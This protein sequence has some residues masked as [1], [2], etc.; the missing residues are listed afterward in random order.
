MATNKRQ[1]FSW[2]VADEIALLKEVMSIQPS[3]VSGWTWV[4]ENLN[5]MFG[6]RKKLTTRGVKTRVDLL[7]EKFGKDDQ[8]GLK[9][10]GTE[11][12]Y[13]HSRTRTFWPNVFYNDTSPGGCGHGR[14]Q[15]IVAGPWEVR[16]L[17]LL[18]L[19]SKR[20]RIPNAVMTTAVMMTVVITVVMR[21]VMTL[22]PR[23][24]A[25]PVWWWAH[26]MAGL[27]K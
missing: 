17:K 20:Y 25:S 26:R 6:E 7:V 16:A 3:T 12:E 19:S 2:R 24:L 27:K 1:I 13:D 18:L 4:V 11:E 9:R 5:G 10:F 8:A 21:T 23:R 22:A 15:D 14:S